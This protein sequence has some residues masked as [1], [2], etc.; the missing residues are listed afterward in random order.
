[1][2]MQ[3]TDITNSS[4]TLSLYLYPISSLLLVSS[5][6]HKQCM[7]KQMQA[8]NIQAVSQISTHVSRNNSVACVSWLCGL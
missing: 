1:M 5:I 6:C 2:D 8:C 4:V 3:D 7:T